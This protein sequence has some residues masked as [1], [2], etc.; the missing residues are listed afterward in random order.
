MCILVPVI[1]WRI[2]WHYLFK[3]CLF[4]LFTPLQPQLDMWWNFSLNPSSLVFA[5]FWVI[6]SSLSSSCCK[7]W[8]FF[9]YGIFILKFCLVLFKICLIIFGNLLLLTRTCVC[10]TFFSTYMSARMYS[11]IWLNYGG[12]FWNLD[13]GSSSKE[14]VPLSVKRS[15]PLPT[16]DHFKMSFSEA[17]S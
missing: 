15:G 13:R 10:D 4:P 1:K 5:P 7:H 8:G 3:Y 11:H 16:Y 12:T 6:F 17:H 2:L 9:L 14:N